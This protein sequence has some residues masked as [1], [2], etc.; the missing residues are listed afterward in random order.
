MARKSER[1]EKKEKAKQGKQRKPRTSKKERMNKQALWFIAYL[2]SF[3]IVFLLAY[4]YFTQPEKFEYRGFKFVEVKGQRVHFY[5][6]FV[7]LLRSD[8]SI[9]YFAVYFR[10]DPRENDVPFDK[11]GEI[12]F[13]R[14]KFVYITINGTGLEDCPLSQ[15]SIA[16]LSFL[17]KNAGLRVHGGLANEEQAN[18]TGIRYV[19]CENRP[20]NVVL[21]LQEANETRIVQTSQ[22]CYVVNVN[23]CEI[24]NALEKFEI[25]A[26]VDARNIA[27]R[28]RG[29]LNK[30]SQNER[31]SENVSQTNATSNN[32]ANTT[33]SN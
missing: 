15:V 10:I 11:L 3:L 30:P 12:S 18:A 31:A 33:F 27:A 9:N 19:T 21:V 6:T 14:G 4:W 20:R 8:G 25:E 28:E 2:L 23:R 22:N 16:S 24:A 1:E 32:S 17:L 7:P 26:M 5:K 29:E 13:P